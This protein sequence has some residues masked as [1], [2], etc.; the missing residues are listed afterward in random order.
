MEAALSYIW[1]KTCA[2]NTVR[3]GSF[4]NTLFTVYLPHWFN[5]SQ[6]F[7]FVQSFLWTTQVFGVIQTDRLL[8]FGWSC[9]GSVLKLHKSTYLSGSLKNDLL[10]QMKQK[11]QASAGLWV[12]EGVTLLE[13]PR[14]TCWDHDPCLLFQHFTHPTFHSPPGTQLLPT[15][16][17][18]SL[19]WN[20]CNQS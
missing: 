11:Q 3:Q 15:F 17:H 12:Q 10:Q 13:S 14:M 20:G 2:V 5:Q 8:V 7:Q 19:S 9:V 18:H 4:I 1:H 16:S 6:Q